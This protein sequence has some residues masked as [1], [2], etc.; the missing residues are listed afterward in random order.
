M[1]GQGCLLPATEHCEAAV[2]EICADFD[3]VAANGAP[4]LTCAGS[5]A[6][7]SGLGGELRDGE[8]ITLTEG[9]VRAVAQVF[10]QLDGTREA[11]SDWNFIK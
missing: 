10:R 11:Q 4:P 5:I 9:E 7:I 6:N 8:E 3:D 1:S 2:K